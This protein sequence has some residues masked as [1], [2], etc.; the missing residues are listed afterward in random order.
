[1]RPRRA[2]VLGAAALLAGHQDTG[3]RYTAASLDCSRWSESSRSRIETFTGGRIGKATVERDG[4][5]TVRAADSTGG[6]FVEGWY[7]SLA[8]RRSTEGGQEVVPDTDGLI[9]GR[10]R[11]LLGP[12][13]RYT[14]SAR[15][16]VPDEVAEVAELAGAFDD[17]FPVLPPRPLAPGATWGD[18]VLRVKRLADTV[19]S[20][21][22]LR[23]FGLTSRRERRETLPHGDTVPVPI[24]QT[25]RE[26]GEFSWDS[27]GLQRR[28]RTIL[29]ETT[30]PPSRRIPQAVRSRVEQQVELVRLPA[31]RCE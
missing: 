18:S 23:R 22:T 25:I 11:G 17:L 28:A 12:R 5:L 4:I 21:R 24:R 6:V 20:G 26:Q 29:V 7:D 9:G 15:P 14:A 10:Y 3:L 27:A 8:A 1:V 31:T 16:F 19:V 30:I 2:A 13:G